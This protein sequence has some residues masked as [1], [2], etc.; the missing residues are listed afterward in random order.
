VTKTAE[1]FSVG[2]SD[3]NGFQ[4]AWRCLETKQQS[5]KHFVYF[6]ECVEDARAAGY[7]VDLAGV[8]AMTVDGRPH[9]GLG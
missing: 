2:T 8:R 1:I 5:R 4:W 6:Y 3:K 7:E 9:H